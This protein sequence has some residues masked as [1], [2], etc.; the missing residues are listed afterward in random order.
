MGN[1]KSWI[2]RCRTVREKNLDSGFWVSSAPGWILTQANLQHQHFYLRVCLEQGGMGV[3]RVESVIQI[4][5]QEYR[6]SASFGKHWLRV[7][8]LYFVASSLQQLWT[9]S[10][11]S[12]KFL[13][14]FLSLRKVTSFI[15]IPHLDFQ[16][17]LTALISFDSHESPL[18]PVALAPSP[19]VADMDTKGP[20]CRKWHHWFYSLD[21]CIPLCEMPTCNSRMPHTLCPIL[22]YL[23]SV[24]NLCSSP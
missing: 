19:F 14:C 13:F 18:K 4:D 12:Y 10:T 23:I 5:P 11:W 20:G 7:Q 6:C 21:P 3:R 22:W 8:S 2:L 24:L 15:F 1:T 9:L 17:V 16:S